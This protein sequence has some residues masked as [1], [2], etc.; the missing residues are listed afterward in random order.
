MQN[1]IDV[2]QQII[3]LAD[4]SAIDSILYHHYFN[5]YLI[6]LGLLFFSP[7]CLVNPLFHNKILLT[8]LFINSVITVFASLA[9]FSFGKPSSIELRT[10][11]NEQQTALLKT[12]DNPKIIQAINYNVAKYGKN[13]YAINKSLSETNETLEEIKQEEDDFKE[14]QQFINPTKFLELKN[15]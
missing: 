11:L 1:N 7:F 4:F 9:V 15:N 3:S 5:V 13:L 14:K 6:L 2:L 8:L 12:I 10:T